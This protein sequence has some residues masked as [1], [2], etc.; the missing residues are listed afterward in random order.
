MAVIRAIITHPSLII[1]DEI[2]AN[3]DKASIQKIFK[4]LRKEQKNSPFGAVFI[5]HDSYILQ[6]YCHRIVTFPMIDQQMH[7]MA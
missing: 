1:F 3:L 5:S 6:H 2:T 7:T 4:L